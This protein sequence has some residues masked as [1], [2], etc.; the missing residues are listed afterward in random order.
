MNNTTWI[1]GFCNDYAR[2]A[3]GFAELFIYLG[4]LMGVAIALFEAYKT[5]REAKA[6]AASG[7]ADAVRANMA[8]AAAVSEV[9]KALI[10]IV[11]A[12]KAWLAM[13]I[14]GIVL[15]WLA[16][17]ATPVF[18]TKEEPRRDPATQTQQS[19][20]PPTPG[21]TSAGN[22]SAGAR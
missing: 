3:L 7:G 11:T 19:P 8:P 4:L 13:V 16:G 1:V 9:L 21:N 15:F 20:P 10:A 22:A 2:K 14:I 6:V 12:A 5:Y 18:C 17:N